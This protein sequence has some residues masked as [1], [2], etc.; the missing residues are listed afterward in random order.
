[1][2]INKYQYDSIWPLPIPFP[3]KKKHH[4]PGLLEFWFNPMKSDTVRRFRTQ[5]QAHW[6][7]GFGSVMNKSSFKGNCL[8]LVF[9]GY[10]EYKH[11]KFPPDDFFGEHQGRKNVHVNWDTV[12][13]PRIMRK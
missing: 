9:R 10:F 2:Y 1:M 13:F 8:L 11:R 7:L 4:Q 5:G 12:S 3:E 6:M